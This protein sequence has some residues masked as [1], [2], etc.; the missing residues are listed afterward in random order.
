MDNREELYK[1]FRIFAVPIY[2]LQRIYGLW[3][4]ETAQLTTAVVGTIVIGLAAYRFALFIWTFIRPS[5]LQR[6]CHVGTG[7]W[8]VVT[9]ATDGIGRA[10][11]DELSNRGF[12]VL[13]HGR[14][15]EKLNRVKKELAAKYPRRT[16]DTVVADA[17]RAD[18]PEQAIVD[19]VTQLPGKLV[20]L[21]NNVGGAVVYPAYQT[22]AAM[23]PSSIDTV[24]NTNARFPVQLTSLLLPIL[25]ENKPALIL[26]CG[27]A[28]ANFGIPY[29]AAYSGTK[30]FIEGF[31]RSLD[32]ELECEGL[33]KDIEVKC[34]TINNTRSA[35]NKTEMPVFTIDAGELVRGTLGKVGDGEVIEFGHWRH[36]VQAFVVG[37]LPGRVLRG[38]LLDQM[39]MRKAVEEEEVAKRR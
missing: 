14:N 3:R 17:S 29:L 38:Y 24:L 15:P 37:L 6:Y 34:L 30:A 32:A 39:R 23:N 33:G 31:T 5:T 18:H 28:T 22:H 7:S 10:W 4:T 11:A 2:Y 19:K 8:A 27:S 12:N 13:L 21:V 9:G 35:G 36:A 16:L 26:N 25:K 1:R 20:I